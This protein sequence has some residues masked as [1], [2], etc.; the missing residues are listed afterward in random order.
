MLRRVKID[1]IAAYLQISP[2]LFFRIPL[3][4]H[5]IWSVCPPEKRILGTY[6]E[7]PISKPYN[8][9]Y[10][11]LVMAFLYQIENRSY[12]RENQ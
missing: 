12:S 10:T 5:A 2:D 8:T 7:I 4:R 9:L 11:V 1:P 6:I 3:I